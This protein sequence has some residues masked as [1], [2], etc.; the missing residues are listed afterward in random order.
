MEFAW[1]GVLDYGGN[2]DIWGCNGSQNYLHYCNAKVTK[3]L[4][5]AKT[6]LNPTIRNKDFQNTDTLMAKSDVP[7]IPLYDL[8]NVVTWKT[9]ISGVTNNPTGITWNTEAW[10][11][12]S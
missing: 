4:S 2:F 8:P 6:Q 5:D 3:Y 1:G 10:K 7:A 12:T 11:W 9:S